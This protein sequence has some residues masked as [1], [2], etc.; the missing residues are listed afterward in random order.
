MIENVNKIIEGLPERYKIIIK[1]Y[2]F[3]DKSYDEISK[4]LNIP[5]NIVKTQLLRAKKS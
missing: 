3:E 1:L 2:Y 5:I 4:I